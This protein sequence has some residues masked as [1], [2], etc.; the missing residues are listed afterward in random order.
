MKIYFDA[1]ALA[2]AGIL[3]LAGCG[4]TSTSTIHGQVAPTGPSATLGLGGDAQTYGECAVDSPKP[5]TQ[6]TVNDP[7]G[8]VI[9]T[10]TLGT[11]RTGTT[12]A[13]GLTLY[14]CTMPFTISSV[15]S[16]PRYGFSIT[17]VP[18]T[19]WVTNVQ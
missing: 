13:G 16:E 4:G 3:A 1:L 12:S 7:S 9:G 18:G 6:I 14:T 17:G 8:K 10:G 11:W 5:S 15:P 2:A 19:T